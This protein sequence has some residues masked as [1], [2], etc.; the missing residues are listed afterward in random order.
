MSTLTLPTKTQ[1][2]ARLA[3]IRAEI[4]RM[5]QTLR[6]LKD[7]PK[8]LT[9]LPDPAKVKAERDRLAAERGRLIKWGRIAVGEPAGEPAGESGD[10]AID[11]DQT[12][13]RK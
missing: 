4:S 13:E 5:D 12:Q 8:S 11:Q 10:E 9:D 3:E 6:L 2:E 7:P 1:I